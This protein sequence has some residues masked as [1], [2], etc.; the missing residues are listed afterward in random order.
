MATHVDAI[1]AGRQHALHHRYGLRIVLFVELTSIRV[2]RG[3]GSALRREG[4]FEAAIDRSRGHIPNRAGEPALDCFLAGHCIP[5]FGQWGGLGF[6]AAILAVALVPLIVLLDRFRVI[7]HYIAQVMTSKARI[8]LLS[9]ANLAGTR[10][11]QALSPNA[12]FALAA[13][14]RSRAGRAARRSLQLRQ[15]L[16]LSRQADLCATVRAAGRAGQSGRR[17]RH[18]H[19]HARMPGCEVP[20]RW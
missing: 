12:Q 10:A 3:L 19:H 16:V 17:Q 6:V 2:G 18:P 7:P 15:R 13:A 20:T 5:S 8:F 1:R 14:L 11:K 4:V 9:P